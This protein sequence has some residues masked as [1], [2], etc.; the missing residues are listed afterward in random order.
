M[1]HVLLSTVVDV[2]TLWPDLTWGHVFKFSKAVRGS[3]GY[4]ILLKA[5]RRRCR[6]DERITQSRTEA[7]L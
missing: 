7:S 5:G 2:Y 6:Q 3:A 4:G 1:D